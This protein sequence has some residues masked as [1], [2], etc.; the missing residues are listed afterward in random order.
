[1]RDKS[2]TVY[3]V[4][5]NAPTQKHNVR[6]F[7]SNDWDPH[8]NVKIADFRIHKTDRITGWNTVYS[9]VKRQY[10]QGFND[11]DCNESSCF[12]I[13]DRNGEKKNFIRLG[14]IEVNSF[15][16]DFNILIIYSLSYNVDSQ[17]KYC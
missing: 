11:K 14:E 13:Y 6:V 16:I 7:S 5:N 9:Q 15:L 12:R 2:G 10:A 1:M 3:S 4:S 8:A 17:Y